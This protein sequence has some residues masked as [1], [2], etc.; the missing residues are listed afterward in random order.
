MGEDDVRARIAAQLPL[1]ARARLAD[2][3]L[4]NAGTLEELEAQVVALW[5]ELATRVA[6][7][8]D[9]PIL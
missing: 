3:V 9:R 6:A 1:D 7:A 2:V 5:A 4:D 8:G